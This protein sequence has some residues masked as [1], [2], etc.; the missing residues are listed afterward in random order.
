MIS[1]FLGRNGALVAFFSST[2]D[3]VGHIKDFHIHP[4]YIGTRELVPLTQ[5][6]NGLDG[7]LGMDL[8]V[9]LLNRGPPHTSEVLSGPGHL[10]IAGDSI[11]EALVSLNYLERTRNTMLGQQCRTNTASSHMRGG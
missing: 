11:H 3:V 6:K 7:S 4:L 1:L 5:G 2:N 10:E 8:R 9:V